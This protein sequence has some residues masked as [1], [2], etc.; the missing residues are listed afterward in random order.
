MIGRLLL[1]A[2][3]YITGG[4]V[5]T[6]YGEKKGK[7][8]REDL[9][10]VKGNSKET[11]KLVLA[12]F[13][14]THKNFLEDLKERVL[15]DENKDFF[16]EKVDEAKVLVKDYKK[17]GEKLVEELKIKGEGYIDTAKEDL[18]KL[19]ED[20]KADLKEL[21]KEAPEKIEKAKEKLIAKFDEVKDKI[22]K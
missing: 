5:A 2:V 4:V 7:K 15:T 13:I 11:Q 19:Y 18:E 16:Y 3:G 22:T 20:K 17:Q 6:L 9:E 1:V 12:N 10:E 21:Q 14:E 8:V